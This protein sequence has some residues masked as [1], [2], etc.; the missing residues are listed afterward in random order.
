[1]TRD[2]TGSSSAK[3]DAA[4]LPSLDDS[5]AALH[6]QSATPGG[7]LTGDTLTDSINS[8]LLDTSV[9]PEQASSQDIPTTQTSPKPNG[10]AA[11]GKPVRSAS[12]QAAE[13][14]KR[15]ENNFLE[16]LWK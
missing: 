15:R 7:N 4:P 5:L 9:Q 13:A 3:E 6:E 10:D 16:K 8:L 2:T 11:D 12:V 1:M 14:A